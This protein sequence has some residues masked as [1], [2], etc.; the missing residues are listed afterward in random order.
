[1]P[2]KLGHPSCQL[3][4]LDLVSGLNWERVEEHVGTNSRD[5][6]FQDGDE[7]ETPLYLAC[8]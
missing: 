7:L 5:A 6:V 3:L 8:Q 2:K 4:L 1:M